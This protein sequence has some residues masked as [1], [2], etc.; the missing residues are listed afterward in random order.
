[1]SKPARM[2]IEEVLRHFSQLEDPR[3]S[4]NRHHPL[5]SV[6]VIAIMAILA[7]ANGPSRVA[8]EAAVAGQRPNR[9]ACRPRVEGHENA[10][11]L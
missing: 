5:T 8:S 2:D 7:G 6:V 10:E 3:S 4:I 9:L 11:T 1:M